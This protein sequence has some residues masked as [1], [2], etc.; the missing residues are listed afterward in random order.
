MERSI[1]KTE[2]KC[3]DSKYIPLET[4]TRKAQVADSSGWKTN[5]KIQEHPYISVVHNG[6]QIENRS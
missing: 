1:C 3:E 4:E 5:V 6:S 2:I